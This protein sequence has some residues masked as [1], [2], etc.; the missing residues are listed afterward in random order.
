MFNMQT[1][2]GLIA[3]SGNVDL[4]QATV[5]WSLFVASNAQPLKASQLSAETPPRIA[6]T[7]ALAQPM[8]RRTDRQ[9]LGDGSA[10]TGS[11]ANQISPR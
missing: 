11:T 10:P 7:G 1:R 8:I 6:I 3:G 5:D 9:T 2:R 4:A